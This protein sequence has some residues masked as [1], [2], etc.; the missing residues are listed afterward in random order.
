MMRCVAP[1]YSTEQT[2]RRRQQGHSTNGNKDYTIIMGINE[3]HS[4]EVW[5]IRY[6]LEGTETPQREYIKRSKSY[7]TITLNLAYYSYRW[8]GWWWGQKKS[9][10]IK[11]ITHHNPQHHNNT[12]TII[13]IE[14][15][16]KRRRDEEEQ[17]SNRKKSVSSS[18]MIGPN[19]YSS[20]LSS[21]VWSDQSYLVTCHALSTSRVSRPTFICLQKSGLGTFIPHREM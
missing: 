14:E 9:N 18:C 5:V 13:I 2:D 19:H 7:Q 17:W 8:N 12:I 20:M 21:W 1:R 4:S 16:E 11:Y 3:D 6:V 10:L 15:E